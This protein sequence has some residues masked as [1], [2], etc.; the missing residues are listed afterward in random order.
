MHHKIIIQIMYLFM[1]L[2][3][4]RT[5]VFSLELD[6]TH[7][8]AAEYLKVLKFTIILPTLKLEKRLQSDKL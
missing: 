1:N 6:F 4:I 3:W 5:G 8:Y 2:F 7:L